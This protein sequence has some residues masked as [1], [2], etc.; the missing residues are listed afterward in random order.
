MHAFL[1]EYHGLLCFIIGLGLGTLATAVVGGSLALDAFDARCN[2]CQGV[3][4]A[5]S[6]GTVIPL[7]GKRP[8]AK[9]ARF[10]GGRDVDI[11]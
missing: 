5:P 8:R 2:R 11:V 1:T 3:P 7:R 9:S 4:D 10:R 6:G